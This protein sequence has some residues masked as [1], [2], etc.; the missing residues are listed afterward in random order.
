M[1]GH[2]PQTACS[3]KSTSGTIISSVSQDGG[4]SRKSRKT[5]NSSS[6]S[7]CATNNHGI[8]E[9]DWRLRS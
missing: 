8:S 2:P 3:A 6:P 5:S 9:V 7:D 4:G 1:D